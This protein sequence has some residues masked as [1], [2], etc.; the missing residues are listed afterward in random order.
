MGYVAVRVLGPSAITVEANSGLFAPTTS[1]TE[2]PVVQQVVTQDGFVETVVSKKRN[3]KL[4]VGSKKSQDVAELAT[5]EV[6]GQLLKR[7]LRGA[8]A[9]S[10]WATL[11]PLHEC[12]S[13]GYPPTRLSA[14]FYLKCY[15][16]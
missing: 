8:V 10:Q 5:R 2:Q 13:V 1:T 12:Q 15:L 16:P 7:R 9:L 6:S 3:K 11:H 4:K 14:P